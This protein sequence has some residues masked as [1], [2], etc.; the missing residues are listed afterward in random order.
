MKFVF[1]ALAVAIVADVAL[2]MPVKVT[3]ADLNGI[4]QDVRNAAHSFQNFEYVR[5]VESSLSIKH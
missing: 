5:A 3:M 2:G 1:F 4:R